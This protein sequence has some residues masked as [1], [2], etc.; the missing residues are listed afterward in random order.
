MYGSKNI[1]YNNK[2]SVAREARKATLQTG[3][4]MTI[5]GHR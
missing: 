1:Q 3:Y 2:R 4:S 5:Y